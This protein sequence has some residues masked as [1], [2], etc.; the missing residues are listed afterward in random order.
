M[1]PLTFPPPNRVWVP[2]RDGDETRWYSREWIE[3][4]REAYREATMVQEPEIK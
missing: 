2:V 4:E 1:R 3:G